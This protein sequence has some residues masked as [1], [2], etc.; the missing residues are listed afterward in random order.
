MRALR[1]AEPRSIK[2]Y[3][4]LL[5]VPAVLALA[6]IVLPLV[7]LLARS[8]LSRFG[9]LITSASALD[10]LEL[11]LRTAVA[12]TVLCVVFGVPLAFVLARGRFPGLRFVRSL[13]L[14]PLV[15]PPVVG[16]L[17]LLYSLGRGGFLGQAIDFGF[18]VSVPFTP[19]AVVLAQT[20]V[21][22][23]FLVVGLEGAIRG[24]G[25]RYELVAGTLGAGPW[26]VFRRVTLPLLVPAI[27]SSVV[28]CFARALGEFGATITFAGS[29]QGVTR[30]LPLQI[31]LANETDV[32][33][34]VALSI[35]LVLL[36]IVV[37]VITRPKALS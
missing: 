18:G 10:A 28:L 11:S 20:F 19:V 4:R 12:S 35:L 34:A 22:M 2:P 1:S 36:A 30:T 15:L 27:G 3:P 25:Q 31:Y 16:G 13:V 26:T 8:D 29:L 21:A 32:D 17:A 5:L 7:G 33:G 6:L 37:I 14:L 23:P 9:E 24:N